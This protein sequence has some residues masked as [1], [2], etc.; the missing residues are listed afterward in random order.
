MT[1]AN[2]VSRLE[3]KFKQ[4]L[5]NISLWNN[6]MIYFVDSFNLLYTAI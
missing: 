5:K 1:C 4:D 2:I 3:K 6:S